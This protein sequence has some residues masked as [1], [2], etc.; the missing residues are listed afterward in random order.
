MT[1]ALRRE[2]WKIL[3][4]LVPTVV[5]AYFLI[6][7]VGSV[8]QHPTLVLLLL[9][10]LLIVVAVLA[11]PLVRNRRLVLGGGFL[12][13]FVTYCLLFSVAAGTHVLEGRRV[14]LEG[15][16]EETP[17][18]V[19]GLSRLGIWHY[20]LA[21]R[22]P[23]MN[24][25]VVVTLPS[26]SGETLEEARR[27]Q[28]DLI[29]RATQ[30]E[31]K[32][33]AFDYILE[34]ASRA[35]GILCFQVDRARE[36]GIPVV[37]GYRVVDGPTGPVR[38][39]PTPQVRQCV[40]EDRL[41]VLTGLR[42]QDGR[43]RM[44]PT[45]HMGDPEL[46]SFSWRIASLLAG[47]DENL[48][49]PGLVQFLA[50][51][52]LPFRFQAVPDHQEAEGFR[53]RFVVVGSSRKG[54]VQATPFDSLPGV[55]IHALAAHSLRT[56]GFFQRLDSRWLLPVIF[57]LCYV[58]T[59][60]QAGG[61]GPRTLW[62]GVGVFGVTILASAGLAAR[63]GYWIDAS[64]P[65]LAVG[66]MGVVLTGGARLHRGRAQISERSPALAV[67]T[68]EQGKQ[69]PFDVFLS[70]NS[71]D[72]DQVIQVA[73]GLRD[74]GLR[75]WIDQWELVPGRPWQE[76]LEEIITSVATAAIMIGPDGIGSWEEPEMRACLDQSA[77][78]DM[79]ILPVLLPGTSTK[80]KLSLFLSGFTW[81][82]LR[83]GISEAGLDRL[84]WGITGIKPN[85]KRTPASPGRRRA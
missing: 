46:R 66:G 16:E 69:G 35:D 7:A 54:D 17:S 1:G 10:P 50:P 53:D 28:A 63:A 75:V 73:S 49:S 82:D 44:V 58:L 6:G 56:G 22:P 78:R 70:Y 60:L 26:F 80:P 27:V 47:G 57:V 23:P 33:I 85:R 52:T 25:I 37:Y 2:Q 45:A 19:L 84:E 41:G 77:N 51:R 65:L 34:E 8:S 48:P 68:D 3:G 62:L 21:P 14:T 29:A 31:A 61:G 38:R 30:A 81:V 71:K 76:A 20:W 15:F 11:V 67:G 9:T 39:F 74:R 24:D 13:F 72:R 32:G 5:A 79:P 83:K 43:V 59:L 12:P 55:V 42:E 18:N 64:Y 4:V 36:A 40:G